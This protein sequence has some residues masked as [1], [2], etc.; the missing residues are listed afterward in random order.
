MPKKKNQIAIK[1]RNH[2]NSSRLKVLM[3]SAFDGIIMENT[4][5]SIYAIN[6]KFRYITFN[7]NHARIVK[8][9]YGVDI[10]IGD[11]SLGFLKKTPEY[12]W[13]RKDF[14]RA[15]KG[16]LFVS[17]QHLNQVQ[18]KD[19][20]IET[21]YNPIFGEHEREITGVAVFVRDITDRKK[22]EEK[23]RILN[24][25]LVSQNWKLAAQEEEL[26][27]TLDELSERNFELDQLMYKTSH[28]LRS[29]LSSILGL[30]NLAHLESTAENHLVYLNK[31]EGRV[32]KLDEF[33]KSM[34]N[35]ARV[36]RSEIVYEHISLK[37]MIEGCIQE[38]EYLDSFS[39]VKTHVAVKNERVL[40]KTDPLRIRIVLS[41]IISN[42][43][44][45]YN[46]SVKSHLKIHA[47]ITPN[48]V[49]ISFRDNGIG[50]KKEYV[51]K[52]FDMFYRATEKS[53]GSGL[54]MYIVK[55]AVD[56]LKGT[57]NVKS[58]FSKGTNIKIIVPNN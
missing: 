43:Y 1:K 6:R 41:N 42:A 36:N 55:Q 48:A 21:T 27:A 45:Y 51:K 47:V 19:R 17:E 49:E 5:E 37:E 44:K 30:I 31:I 12:K 46:P 35:Y 7:K 15:L 24:D 52:V 50:I 20:Y 10:S 13:L 9:I 40:F 33:I 57:I 25:G 23:L 26:K 14:A 39:S 16:E 18:Y 3:E 56:K 54:G 22:A 32:K 38:L 2:R 4:R 28:D 8:L 58:T 53:Q 11:S 29:P 34:L